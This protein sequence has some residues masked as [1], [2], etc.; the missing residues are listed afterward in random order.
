MLNLSDKDIDRLSREAADS[1][2]PDHSKL[3]WSRLE[4]KLTQQMP[5]RP[6]DG[7][8]FGR[9]KPYVWGPAL[10]I[11]ATISF[12]LI[13]NNFYS[14]LSTPTV[15]SVNKTSAD[16]SSDKTSS[17]KNGAK[18]NVQEGTQGETTE[19]KDSRENRSAAETRNNG[20]LSGTAPAA[21]NSHKSGT[22]HSLNGDLMSGKEASQT[23]GR[24]TG[25]A[26]NRIPVSGN[27]SN[28]SQTGIPDRN[29]L[30]NA[31]LPTGRSAVNPAAAGSRIPYSLPPLAY[32]GAHLG[33]VK[34]NDS[35]LNRK[36][37]VKSPA[38][39]KTVHINRSL[40]FGFAFGPDYTDAGGIP[41]NQFGNNI[42]ITVGYYL[43]SRLSV[44]S[45]IFYS[46]KFYWTP[47][48]GPGRPMRMTGQPQVS[49]YAAAAP[50]YEYVNGSA[51]LYELPLTL[52]Y[53]IGNSGKSKFFANA[54]LSS[55]FI[56]NQS[57]IY[58]F[59]SGGRPSAWKKTDNSQKNYWFDIADISLGVE[60]D[61]GKGFSFQ[62]EP[63]LKLPLKP[64]GME[65]AK[66]STYGFL[67]SI[68]FTPELTK[69][70]K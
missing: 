30:N 36:G 63:F 62:A 9:I 26:D 39:G 38:A 5:E 29:D 18:E 49:A 13:K 23:T 50:T 15:Q 69:S 12:Y 55:Y 24:K 40:N 21:A 42:G 3:S 6:P 58:F 19:E 68:R 45:G 16:S 65:N 66:L 56:I 48:Y 1:F 31:S 11:I 20:N 14:Q 41:N 33:S 52:R 60:T 32:A 2:E 47:G 28:R 46:N 64:M 25:I 27:A 53:D 37:A 54:G 34:G 17:D 61:M 4:Q 10:A 7:F 22:S 59:H 35:L 8:A 67:L 70:K 57:S 44:N 51:N 43:T